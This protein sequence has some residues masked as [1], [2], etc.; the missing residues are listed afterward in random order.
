[1]T[2][3]G[4]AGAAF[5]DRVIIVD[6]HPLF[7]DALRT[8]IE[9][10]R[11][12]CQVLEAS[13]IEAALALLADGPFHGLVLLDLKMPEG[14]GFAGMLQIRAKYPQAPIAIVTANE[15]PKILVTALNLGAAGFI[16]KSVGMAELAQALEAI[17]S[18]DIWAP[19]SAAAS[20]PPPDIAALAALSPAQIR[21]L[22][23]LRRGML[24]KQ[25]AFE[26]DVTEATVKAHMSALFRKLNVRNRTQA[27]ILA[28]VLD[29]VAE[30][31]D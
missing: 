16:P 9:R 25:I 24:N 20:T 10:I 30:A 19:S 17:L 8:A 11:P 7:R 15:D 2:A 1:M 14:G 22:T 13:T 27:L 26:L 5:F 18:G 31:V 3:T 4:Q 12:N 28:Q 29:P 23:Y 21:I 6:D